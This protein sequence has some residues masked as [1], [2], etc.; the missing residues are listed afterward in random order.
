MIFTI[1][2]NLSLA[3]LVINNRRVRERG[4]LCRKFKK[5]NKN[6]ITDPPAKNCCKINRYR[7]YRN[8]K[9]YDGKLN[10]N[11]SLTTSLPPTIRES[12]VYYY[13]NKSNAICEHNEMRGLT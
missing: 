13:N 7:E 3:I 10:S 8:S 6:S 11:Y 12:R 5:I 1:Y 2:D 4:V 9:E